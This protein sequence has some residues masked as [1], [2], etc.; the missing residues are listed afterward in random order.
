MSVS[1]VPSLRQNLLKKETDKLGGAMD[2]LKPASKQA[3]ALQQANNARP[4]GRFGTML[5]GLGD[6]LDG[7]GGV[8]LGGGG[9]R[10]AH[11]VVS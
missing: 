11:K 1:M 10:S 2:A 6:V 7:V 8:V 4:V 5:S 9:S 3:N